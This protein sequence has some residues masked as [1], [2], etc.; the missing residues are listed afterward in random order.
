MSGIEAITIGAKPV[1][2][3]GA[4]RSG[5]NM[6]RDVLTQV[7]TIHTWPCDEINYIWRYGNRSFVTDE[8]S[9]DMA[10]DKVRDYIRMQFQSLANTLPMHD[11]SNEHVVLEKTC[12]NSLRVEFVDVVL[13]EARYIYLVRDGRDVVASA[14]KRWK[15][16]LDIPYLAAKAKYVPKSDLPY[17]AS[18]YLL[19][20][21]QKIYN[22]E[23][24]LGIWGP[25]FEGWQNTV[26][27]HDLATVCATQWARCVELSN[28]AFS[29]IAGHR[30]HK[31]R[32]EDFVQNP[33][34][35]TRAITDFLQ[36]DADKKIISEACAAISTASIGKA[37]LS[38]KV[39]VNDLDIM[40][41]MLDALGYRPY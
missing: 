29:G 5:T 16:P 37:G 17:Y 22:P 4:G 38:S 15:A 21:V 10:T 18:H 11:D 24:R 33:M 9:A 8:F 32:Y 2:I 7:S 14:M 23:A 1:I 28:Q 20:R 36:L 30:V 41:P 31:L 13:P 25:K 19:N 6:L 27:N 39:S 3:I 40:G 35:H 12:A 26:A 34:A